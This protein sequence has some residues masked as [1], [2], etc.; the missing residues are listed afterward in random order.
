MSRHWRTLDC[1]VKLLNT[2]C[3]QLVLVHSENCCW[4]EI[5]GLREE[6]GGFSQDSVL[7]HFLR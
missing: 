5:L 4:R 2:V 7:A 1:F 6:S 3:S